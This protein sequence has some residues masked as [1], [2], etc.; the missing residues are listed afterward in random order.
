MLLPSDAEASATGA[1]KVVANRLLPLDTGAGAGAAGKVAKGLLKGLL[2]PLDAATLFKGCENTK[3][4]ADGLLSPS[5]D[6]RGVGVLVVVVVVAKA[7]ESRLL[8]RLF[9]AF[10]TGVAPKSNG[11]LI[12]VGAVAFATGAAG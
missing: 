7:P 3:V 4:A 9:P 10:A 12:P 8:K 1:E 6:T 5:L 2:L 11:L